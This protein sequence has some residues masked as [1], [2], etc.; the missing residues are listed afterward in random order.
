M[1]GLLCS[2][3]TCKMFAPNISTARFVAYGIDALKMSKSGSPDSAMPSSNP[4]PRVISAKKGGTEKGYRKKTSFKSDEISMSL[5]FLSCKFDPDSSK[6][7]VR[8][9]VKIGLSSVTS[10]SCGRKPSSLASVD[11]R[12]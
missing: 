6:P 2:F 3:P 1:V 9:F 11:I 12:E 5:R 7:L 4:K 8:I 10:I